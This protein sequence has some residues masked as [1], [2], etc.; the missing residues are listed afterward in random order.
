MLRLRPADRAAVLRL[1]PVALRVEAG[2][3]FG[4]VPRLAKRL[5]ISMDERVGT[6]AWGG[7]PLSPAER[8][9]VD[10]ARR[11]VRRWPVEARCLRRSLLVGHVLRGR[12]PALRL[13]VAKHD[14]RV[15]AHAWIE[16]DGL[17]P[18]DTEHGV[19]FVPLRRAR[20][21]DAE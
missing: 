21:G 13:G 18:E 1:L 9:G 4:T 16:V 5:G 11:I 20:S 8:R 19:T 3:R 17:I 12:R 14:G 15:H 2:L 6:P 7:V 10:A